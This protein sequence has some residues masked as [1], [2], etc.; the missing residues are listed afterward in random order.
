MDLLVPAVDPQ[1]ELVGVL[2]AVL[3]HAGL[4]VA[5]G[6][7]GHHVDA[8]V[9]GQ[10]DGQ[11]DVEGAQGGEEGVEGLLCDQTHRVVLRDGQHSVSRQPDRFM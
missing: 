1:G 5:G 6:A 7:L 10:D 3:H 9:H 11:R 4:Q 8:A 2:G